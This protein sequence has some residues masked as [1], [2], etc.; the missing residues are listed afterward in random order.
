MTSRGREVGG[1]RGGGGAWGGGGRRKRQIGS[2]A[3]RLN[4]R[5]YSDCPACVPGTYLRER[6]LS[7]QFRAVFVM[8][9]CGQAT[10]CP[11]R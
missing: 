7:A 8:M 3:W 2:K 9:G 11:S 1:G 5:H 6:L 4:E 10:G